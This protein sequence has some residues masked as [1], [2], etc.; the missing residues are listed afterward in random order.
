MSDTDLSTRAARRP[1]PPRI[2]RS[3][4]RALARALATTACVLASAASAAPARA[5]A[6]HHA[7]PNQAARADADR[8]SEGRLRR[9][10][11]PLRRRRLRGGAHQVRERVR[12]REGRAAP[13]E[14]R[15]VPE[16][17]A[18]LL[19]GDRAAAALQGRGRGAPHAGRRPGRRGSHRRARALHGQG[20]LQGQRGRRR[21]LGGRRAGRNDAARCG[22]RR[23]R[24]AACAGDEGW[25]CPVREDGPHR[26][27]RGHESR[28][29]SRRRS[30]RGSSS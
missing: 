4:A 12:D 16:G 7:A 13:L 27:R 28:R 26:R 6:G 30:T 3:R 11:A 20:H 21:R 24:R 17:A 8:A 5:D 2:V 10:E 14:H 19:E 9:R 23:C 15:D 22:R 29:S 18:P 25:L 1:A